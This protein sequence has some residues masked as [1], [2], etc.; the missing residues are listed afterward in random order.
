[1]FKVFNV[2]F[3]VLLLAP[4]FHRTGTATIQSKEAIAGLN[5]SQ[6]LRDDVGGYNRLGVAKEAYGPLPS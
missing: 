2:D 3:L 1:M 4:F 5:V 6:I